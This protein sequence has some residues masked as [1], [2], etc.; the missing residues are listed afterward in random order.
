MKSCNPVRS[1]CQRESDLTIGEKFIETLYSNKETSKNKKNNTLPC[2]LHS[3][4][5]C[6]QFSWGS[7]NSGI[8]LH[9]GDGAEKAKFSSFEVRKTSKI[10]LKTKWHSNVATTTTG[11][12]LYALKLTN[13]NN[14]RDG[15]SNRIGNVFKVVISDRGKSVEACFSNFV[16]HVTL[17]AFQFLALSS[18]SSWIVFWGVLKRRPEKTSAFAR[19]LGS[20]THIKS[21]YDQRTLK[22]IATEFLWMQMCK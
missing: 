16:I 5:G 22:L 2:P 17:K 21:D 11:S 13:T 6:L 18:R 10:P 14:R 20:W 7:S 4:L 12:V 8:T 9:E 1:K 19:S 15:V 3:K